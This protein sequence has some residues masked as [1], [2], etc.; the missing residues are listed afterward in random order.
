[1]QKLDYVLQKNVVGLKK[2]LKAPVQN[3]MLGYKVNVNQSKYL[4]QWKFTLQ[5]QS[6]EF[7]FY[8]LYLSNLNPFYV[9]LI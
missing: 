4:L 7:L 8:F 9:L 1:M 2:M 5:E 3:L 6:V